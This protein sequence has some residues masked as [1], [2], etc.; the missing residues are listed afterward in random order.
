MKA[1][2]TWQNESAYHPPVT[3]IMQQLFRSPL[4]PVQELESRLQEERIR[5]ERFYE[6][7][8]EEQK[9]EFINGEVIVQSPA[10]LRHTTTGRNLLTLLDTYVSK[11]GLGCVGYEKILVTLTRNDYEPDIVYFGPEKARRLTPEQMKFPAPDIVVEVLSPL[12]ESN[13]RGLKFLDYAAHGIAEYW[14]IDPKAEMFEQYVLED[15]TYRLRIKTDSGTIRSVV[16]G[17]FAVPVRAIFDE[18]EKIAALQAILS[19][20]D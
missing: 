10:Q 9:V 16:L 8:S 3:V 18:D 4:L 5:R 17:G 20:E 19:S 7:M 14:I 12:T 15:E 6:E 13:D 1:T 2:G 11:H